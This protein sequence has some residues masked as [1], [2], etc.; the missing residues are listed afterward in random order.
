MSMKNTRWL[1]VS[2]F[3][4]AGVATTSMAAEPTSPETR[5]EMIRLIDTLE[6][7]PTAPNSK[8]MRD[9]VLTWL[10]EAPDVSVTMCGKFLGIE[11]FS[12]GRPGGELIVQQPFAEAK[13]IL[14][15]PDQA[16]DEV[17]VHVAGIE[18]ALRTYAVMKANDPK[19]SIPSMEA[20]VKVQAEQKLP[21]HVR[22]SLA[23]CN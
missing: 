17:A 21:D 11:N 15:H 1:V 20:L 18:G 14:E 5:A 2:L 8:E 4:L 7:N 22:K 10:T 16:N 9:K 23:K 19:F 13:F 12:T 3:T 6:K